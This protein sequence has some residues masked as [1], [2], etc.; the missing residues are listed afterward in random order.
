MSTCTEQPPPEWFSGH[1]PD[2]TPTAAPRLALIPLPF[3]G[4][5]Q[6]DGRVM[7]L[8]LVLPTRLNP[9]EL[10]HC[11]EAFLYDQTTGLTRE[12]R[13]FSSQRFE[14]LLE[15]ET[16][17]CPTKNLDPNVWTKAS[18]TW[19][20]VTPIVLNRHFDGKNKW[21]QT[22]ESVKDMCEH[23]GLPRPRLVLLHP[24][25]LIEGTPPAREYPQLAR[26]N[27][28]GRRRHH[29]AIII[30]DKPVSGPVLVGAGRFR[31]YGLCHPI[32]EQSNE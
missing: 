10:G 12:H 1:R 24:V 11:L 22:T 25:S 8:A 3:V 28:D 27:N 2:G 26:K 30:F 6:A 17:E 7:G 20:S 9:G 14:C 18:R 23:T 29:H 21:E 4:S 13:L 32:N 19:A 16:S 31:G 5:P 15:L